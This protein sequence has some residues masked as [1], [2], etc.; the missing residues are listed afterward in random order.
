MLKFLLK[1][2]LSVVLFMA[3]AAQPVFGV[4]IIGE[5][6]GEGTRQQ[7]V[8][9]SEGFFAGLNAEFYFALPDEWFDQEGN[10]LVVVTRDTY[11]DDSDISDILD[12]YNISFL[13]SNEL[14]LVMHL[15]V[16]DRF[17]WMEGFF[18]LDVVMRTQNYIFAVT[19]G[20]I[21]PL[22]T[23][24]EL[25]TFRNVLGAVSGSNSIADL[26]ELPPGQAEELEFA[27]IVDGEVIPSP[28]A[29]VNDR[30]YVPL[31]DVSA[32]LGFEIEWCSVDR[33]VLI[34]NDGEF[35]DQFF[36][37]PGEE[38]VIS[39]RYHVRLIND[40]VHVVPS[41]IVG[42]FRKNV[43]IDGASNVIITSR[44]RS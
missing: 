7:P 23:L 6:P 17:L 5:E 21:S 28:V 39:P 33:R 8:D 13:G 18:P 22:M 29:F 10:P 37:G 2:T 26:I 43:Q 25:E 9:I 44:L 36:L 30:F 27:I 40:R 35:V 4:G 20:G 14:W 32:A 12:W 19:M 38:T 3:I 42:V 41:Y 1:S 16:F 15:Y 11:A 24:R 31:R 34:T